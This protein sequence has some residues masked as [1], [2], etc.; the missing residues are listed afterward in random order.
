MQ[1]LYREYKESLKDMAV[2]EMVD[3]YLFRPI[4]FL[5]VKLL[6]PFPITPNQVSALSMT[7]GIAAGV[8]YAFGD[9]KSF[10]YASLLYGLSH[11]LDCAD[12]M[13]ARLK[14][15]GSSIGRIVDGWADYVTSAAVYTGLLIGL[16]NG[17]FTLPAASP[18]LLMVPASICYA[19]HCMA[20]DYYRHEFMAHAL[21][22]AASV[23]QYLEECSQLLRRLNKEKGK[24][25]TKIMIIFY[26][27]YTRLQLKENGQKRKKS[28]PRDKYYDA[29]KPLLFLWN[30][31]GS[32]TH[33]AV[34][35]TAALVYEPM[36]FFYF[37][38]GL[39]NAWMAVLG[40][41][42]IKTNNKIALK[43]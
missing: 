31:I 25:L 26:L 6:Y 13:L 2:E 21:G 36:I 3:L 19:L 34:L 20:V 15:N 39:A 41:V 23:R 28:Y 33:I 9:R 29:N 24:Y 37:T 14:K 27:G 18:W 42:Q 11:V 32:A 8:F 35:I 16:H 17:S 40:V 30:W 7:A 5:V 10:V 1:A 12:G 22:K 43:D 38:L 4:A